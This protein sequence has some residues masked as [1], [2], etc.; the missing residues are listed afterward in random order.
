MF[1]NGIGTEQELEEG[2]T[3]A[4]Y[5]DYKFVTTE[6]L[7]ELGLAHLIG[8]ALLRAYMHGYFVDVR[9]FRKFKSIAEPFSMQRYTQQKVQE[10]IAQQRPNRV[11]IQVRPT[12]P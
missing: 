10:R 9:L 8:T 2:E 11:Q 5:D 3:T 6:E 12:L 4:V 7:H 1:W